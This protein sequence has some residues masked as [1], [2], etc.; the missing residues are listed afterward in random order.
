[1][2]FEWDP[3]KA[4]EN[5]TKHGVDFSEAM[6]IFISAREATAQERRTYESNNP[7]SGN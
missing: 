7:A 5:A 4:T 2:H 3:A 1:V 6:T